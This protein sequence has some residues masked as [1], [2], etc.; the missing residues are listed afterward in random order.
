[1]T[2]LYF[3]T[4]VQKLTW[5][6][7]YNIFKYI[8]IFISG[9]YIFRK[10]PLIKRNLNY[11][12]T[13]FLGLFSVSTIYSAIHNIGNIKNRKVVLV[14]II[15]LLTI[16]EFYMMLSYAKAKGKVKDILLLY[17]LLTIVTVI[18]TDIGVFFIPTLDN[19]NYLIGTKFSVV[20]L[21]IL[22]IT[23]YLVL[24]K[25]IKKRNNKSTLFFLMAITFLISLKVECATGIVGLIIYTICY[26]NRGEF[27]RIFLSMKAFIISVL[28]VDSFAVVYEMVL[29]NRYIQNIISNVFHRSLTLTGRVNIYQQL[30]V[31]LNTNLIWGNGCGSA[32]EIMQRY[33]PYA[34][35]QNGLAQWIL[36]IGIVGTSLLF[37]TL[38]F[39]FKNSRKN[40]SDQGEVEF[41]IL[42]FMFIVLSA[43]EITFDTLFII[44]V[45]LMEAVS[46]DN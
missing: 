16:W 6:F 24:N 43:I 37:L 7:G 10:F 15:F 41:A 11:G 2:C 27:G 32:Y 34:D 3:I 33:T 29:N 39:C 26:I 19:G 31:I 28:A 38:A 45:L 40:F 4:V 36:Q 35:A 25:T 46:G 42:I 9:V 20:Y 22:L 1:M 30:P 12:I 18:V 5:I 21:H 23:L 17:K 8:I 44:V 14:T 13:V